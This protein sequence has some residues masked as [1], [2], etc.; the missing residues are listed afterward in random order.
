MFFGRKPEPEKINAKELF[1]L[2]NRLFDQKIGKLLSNA[3]P[4][5][6]QLPGLREDFIRD[7]DEFEKVD[8]KPY[9]E[10]MWNPN[11]NA[12][13]SQKTAYT[14][15]L[16]NLTSHFSSEVEAPNS[17]AKYKLILMNVDELMNSILKYN[18]NYKTVLYCYPSHLKGFKKTF[19]SIEQLR[20][21][22]KA[23]LDS[24]EDDYNKYNS[25]GSRISGLS[26]MTEEIFILKESIS[27]LEKI[28]QKQEDTGLSTERSKLAE[29]IAEKRK[30]LSAINQEASA[31]KDRIRNQTISLDRA[32]KKF[33][34]MYDRKKKL[35]DFVREP[36][37]TLKND[38]DNNEFI[39]LLTEM[40]DTITK[41]ENE[42]EPMGIKNKDEVLEAIN[43][44]INSEIYYQVRSMDSF[45]ERVHQTESEIRELERSYYSIDAVISGK[46]KAANAI[47]KSK[48]DLVALENKRAIAKK[49]IEDMFSESYSRNILIVG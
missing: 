35:N 5:I 18:S 6:R 15:T 46:D 25:I 3:D 22:L 48:A 37:S 40:R 7:C 42:A 19:T 49:E 17:Y 13:K 24:K 12:I 44:I 47:E 36:V 26:A 34:H 10:Y 33:D 32:S 8:V 14:E 2:L 11:P 23:E 27:A 9:T 39:R 4:I 16:R 20:N 30:E 29:K 38:D 28:S 45:R 1:P 21:A 31:S 41:A 43:K